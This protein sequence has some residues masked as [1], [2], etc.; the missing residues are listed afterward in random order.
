MF[1][2]FLLKKAQ[3]YLFVEKI[4]ALEMKVEKGFK[5]W[6]KSWQKNHDNIISIFSCL[7]QIVICSNMSFEPC[8]INVS[9]S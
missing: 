8:S 3:I 1:F 4:H 7:I 6:L 5:N 2:I 9:D